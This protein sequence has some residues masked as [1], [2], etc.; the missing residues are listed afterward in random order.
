M[1]S[2][3]SNTSN[4]INNSA[5]V[6]IGSLPKKTE[7]IKLLKELCKFG[8]VF[9][10][11][12]KR[13]ETNG[14]CL[15]YGHAQVSKHAY[16][17]LI[18]IKSLT[19]MGRK[20][21]FGPYLDGNKLKSHLTSL[22][23]KRIFVRN[24]PKNSTQESLITLFSDI[25]KVETAYLRNIPGSRKP[26][27]VIIFSDAKMA[28]K[29]EKFINGTNTGVF[30]KIEATY[31]YVTNFKK[32]NHEANRP[33]KND[34]QKTKSKKTERF[35]DIRPGKNGYTGYKD[36]KKRH[37]DIFNIILNRP[38]SLHFSQK[39]KFYEGDSVNSRFFQ[40]KCY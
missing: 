33:Y 1:N 37:Y 23:S 6:F 22:N 27:G 25:A 5:K 12:T 21:T 39:N 7:D 15:G 20:I 24:I 30:K 4:N 32:R 9:F 17:R 40:W 35:D 16:E 34:S 2:A 14:E 8:E 31:K 28:E 26:I 11:T 10:L 29:A 13:K 38:K 36:V 19:F 3:R 18:D